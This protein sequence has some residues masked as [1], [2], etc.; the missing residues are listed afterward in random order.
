M[1]PRITIDFENGEGEIRRILGV[2]E[3]R[4]F[5]ISSIALPDF[6][7]QARIIVGLKPR[8]QGRSLDVLG[9]QIARLHNV[10]GVQVPQGQ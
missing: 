1:D 5:E 2:I 9:R 7:G 8:G 10:R 3:Q 6:D 4:G